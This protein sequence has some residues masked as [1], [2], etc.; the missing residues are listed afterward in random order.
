MVTS[1]LCFVAVIGLVRY[2]GDTLPPAESAFIRYAVGLVFFVPYFLKIPRKTFNRSNVWKYILRGM[3]HSLAAI[4]WF[5]AMT[6]L[7]VAEV[8]AIGY[9]TPVFV[10]IGAVIFFREKAS[11]WRALAFFIAFVGVIVILRP[12]F[13][14]FNLGRGSQLLATFFFAGSYLITK[15]LTQ[16][17]D[18]TVIVAM[19]SLIVTLF[20]A[21]FAL[22][23]WVHP[24]LYSVLTLSV[25]AFFATAGHFAMTKSIALAPL[26]VIQPIT[27]LQLV[28]S[29]LLGFF[30]FDDKIDAF[31][32]IGAALIILSITIISYRDGK[33]KNHN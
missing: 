2:L 9:L 26:V 29:V 3:V 1:G 23:V 5:F 32:I 28:W 6:K 18:S 30:L 20:L 33:R 8:T 7:V 24:P 25:V 31:V 22:V 27:F 21:P 15:N 19:L 11:F 16:S 10:T 17:E 13:Q 12:G 4:C 14:E